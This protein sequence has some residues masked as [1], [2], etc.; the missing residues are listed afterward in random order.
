VNHLPRG[1]KELPEMTVGFRGGKELRLE[2]GKL[3]L[4]VNDV[5]EEVS[6]VGRVVGREE[7]LKG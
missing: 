2:V 1:S 5:V 6:R 3:G 7:S 4:S